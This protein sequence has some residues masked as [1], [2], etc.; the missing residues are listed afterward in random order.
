MTF[1]EKRL[2]I[3]L[4]MVAV[5]ALIAVLAPQANAASQPATVT[6]PGGGVSPGL[7]DGF[8]G[9]NFTIATAPSQFPF[10]AGAKAGHC[11][12]RTVDA[13]PG[14]A[15]LQTGAD[16]LMNPP[17]PTQDQANTI[18]WILLSS[19]KSQAT[20][21]P[22]LTPGQ[23]AGA[24]QSAIWQNTDA[25]LPAAIVPGAGAEFAAARARATAVVAQAEANKSAAQQ[26]AGLTPIGTPV[27]GAG[28]RTVQV[29]GAPFGSASLTITSA[30]GTFAGGAKTATV[31]LGPTGS[32]QVAVTGAVGTVAITASVPQATLVK[33]DFAESQDFAYVETPNVPVS[34]NLPFP[35]CAGGSATG[36][37]T[38]PRRASL[39]VTK[40]GPSRVRAGNTATYTVRVRNTARVAARGVVVVDRLPQGMVLTG[41]SSGLSLRNGVVSL[42]IGTIGA[43]RTV[44]RRIRLRM[45]ASTSG[46]R[47]N[48]VTVTA[49]NARSRGARVCTTVVR[50]R[51][52][53]LP[54]VTG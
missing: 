13:A 45:L 20:P 11:V 12:E 47:C 7:V 40:T 46:Q 24:H 1:A 29:K 8:G 28:T 5:L 49:S 51:N 3:G 30:N 15:T 41:A 18:A 25:G 31:D 48:R 37:G 52:R 22:G 35:P 27:C 54:A 43:R 26:A 32:A 6:L 53:V 38:T 9:Y 44:V 2:G 14:V 39:Q 23:E 19:K 33:V 36:G 42:R 17:P 10:I 50:V 4:L 21:S 34:L 16:V